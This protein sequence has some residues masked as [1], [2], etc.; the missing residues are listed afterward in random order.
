[1]HV[2]VNNS[3]QKY[4]KKY[5]WQKNNVGICP[6]FPLFNRKGTNYVTI[7]VNLMYLLFAEFLPNVE[8]CVRGNL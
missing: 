6:F 7:V 1:M 4:A 5:E 3:V 2:R 8:A